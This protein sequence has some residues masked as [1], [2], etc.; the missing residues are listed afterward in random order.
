[1]KTSLRNMLNQASRLFTREIFGDYRFPPDFHFASYGR[2]AYELVLDAS[3]SMDDHDYPPSRF[4]AAK[5]AATG[6]L[7]KCAQQTPEALVGVTFY[8]EFSSV[9]AP[10]LPAKTHLHQLRQA[11]DAG[12]IEIATNIGAGLIA[13]GQELMT[14][15]AAV[16]PT[17]LLLTDG[18]SNTGPDPVQIASQLKAM[19]VRLDIIGI[20]GSPSQVNE[21]ELK[22]MAS[23]LDGQL[24]YWFIRDT[25]TLVRKFE[26]LA[27]GK[28]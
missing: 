23:I 6:F 14:L 19:N 16:S 12:E 22:Q 1:M 4:A 7:Q 24:R 3:P 10:L 11:I 8:A 9:A 15:G 28:L 27:L 21:A 13:A 18:Y 26:A 25:T 20:G 17:I 2:L 5:Q